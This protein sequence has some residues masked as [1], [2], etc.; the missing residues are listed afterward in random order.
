MGISTFRAKG[1]A[2]SI[3]FDR[4][5]LELD[6]NFAVA[7]ASLGLAYGNLGQASLAAENIKKAYDLRDRVSERE[8]YRISSAK[9]TR[10][11]GRSN[12][13]RAQTRLFGR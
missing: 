8:R 11:P 10:A 2:E 9:T 13:S 6:P 5:A 1:S 12:G 7:Y 3:P 4:R